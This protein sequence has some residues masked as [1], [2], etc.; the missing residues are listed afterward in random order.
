ME[1]ILVGVELRETSLGPV[2]HA[3]N[4]AK[5]IRAKVHVLLVDG[6]ERPHGQGQPRQQARALRRQAVEGLIDQ[7]RREGLPV[8][9]YISDGP[10]ENETVKLIQENAISLL[11]VG[12][13]ASGGEAALKE[14]HKTLENIRLRV[15]CHI[16]VVQ[17]RD[18]SITT[19]RE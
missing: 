14:F 1:R 4:L 18:Q 2:I 16:E 5:R 8:D 3:I 7:A 10:L 6:A 11:V 15:D 9:Y 17:E 12:L 19:E 13:P